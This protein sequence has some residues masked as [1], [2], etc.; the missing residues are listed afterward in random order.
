MCGEKQNAIFIRR[1]APFVDE[2]NEQYIIP[3]K[4]D[5]RYNASKKYQSFYSISTS[6][7][8]NK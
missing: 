3:E 2:K 6:F 7:A 4:N 5:E 1:E 8:P